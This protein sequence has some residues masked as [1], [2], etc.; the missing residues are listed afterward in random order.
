M[1]ERMACRTCT[2]LLSL[3][4]KPDGS[5]EWLHITE[6]DHVPDPVP[7]DS[8]KVSMLCDFCTAEKPDYVLPMRDFE[9]RDILHMEAGSSLTGGSKGNWAVCKDCA[10]FIDTDNWRG[11]MRR[12]MQC[13]EDKYGFPI[14]PSVRPQVWQGLMEARSNVTGRLQVRDWSN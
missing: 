13:W 2:R 11:A 9:Y 4:R 5:T 6:S 7:Q 8:I 12:M 10:P 1:S 3:W 14:E